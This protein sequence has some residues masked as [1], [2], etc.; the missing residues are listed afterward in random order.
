MEC[1]SRE[2]VDL[3]LHVVVRLPLEEGYARGFEL[4]LA[5]ARAR[6][7]YLDSV[8]VVRGLKAHA[9]GL[10]EGWAASLPV[11]VVL[12]EATPSP[13]VLSLLPPRE[14][15][16]GRASPSRGPARGRCPPTIR[17]CREL[18][19][20]YS[21][22]G[23]VFCEGIVALAMLAPSGKRP[24]TAG[25]VLSSAR[26]ADVGRATEFGAR[27][28]ES[29]LVGPITESFDS[30]CWRAGGPHHFRAVGALPIERCCAGHRDGQALSGWLGPR[31]WSSLHGWRASRVESRCAHVFR[32]PK[33]S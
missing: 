18:W 12:K 6:W 11:F 17:G 31:C 25:T 32:A 14:P 33:P 26:A 20:S 21:P 9:R 4:L 7:E 5:G 16:R 8:E 3:N 23:Y 19:R 1:V 27:A 28:G 13:R 30:S 15:A 10:S 22:A 24:G 29:V 2:R